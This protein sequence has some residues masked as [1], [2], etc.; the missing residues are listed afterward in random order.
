LDPGRCTDA[1][2]AGAAQA[3]L[4]ANQLGPFTKPAPGLYPHQWNWDAGFIALGYSTF[5]FPQACSELEHLFRG[6]WSNGKVPQILFHIA[7]T[8]QY[9]P[10]YFFWQTAGVPGKPR[11]VRTSGITMPPV[12]GFVLARLLQRTP[13]TREWRPYFRKMFAKI[14]ALHRYCYTIR[15]P[16]REGLAFICHPWESGMD[17]LP[18]WED[19]LEYLH[20][21]P[22][23]VPPYQRKD[24][25][26]AD[27]T[28]RPRKLAYDRFIYLVNRLRIARYDDST[29]WQDFPFQVQEPLFNTMLCHS[30]EGLREVGA[31]L[32]CDTG[33]ILEWEQQTRRALNTKLWDEDRGVYNAYDRVQHKIIEQ[34][35]ASA[36]LPLLCGAPNAEQAGR[37]AAWLNKPDFS[38]TPEYPTYLCPS[39]STTEPKFDDRRYW[40]GPVWININWLL[41]HGLR[42]YGYNDLANRLR[43]DA[44]ELVRKFGF[45]EYYN[46]WRNNPTPEE[47]PGYGSD[48]FSWTAALILDWLA[49]KD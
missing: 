24:L 18:V 46:P 3:V 44:F 8:G 40:R 39:Y 27:P 1:A 17:N 43:D 21:T 37:I 41:Y 7:N 12:H 22:E 30:N 6:Q 5:D 29:L 13:D 33:E 14:V 45:W 19:A 23:E 49:E 15:D 26:H 47:H 2:L 42:R 20:F 38:G 35:S 31:W 16:E 25:D 28:H 4:Y 34:H 32:R 48:Q 36:L 11:N 10:G 9:F